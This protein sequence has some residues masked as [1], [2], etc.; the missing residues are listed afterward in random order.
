MA[1]RKQ[2]TTRYLTGIISLGYK[3]T[4]RFVMQYTEAAVIPLSITPLT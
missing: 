1:E 3:T 2:N 4:L